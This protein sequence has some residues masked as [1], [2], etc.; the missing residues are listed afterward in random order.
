MK[1]IISPSKTMKPTISSYLTDQPPIYPKEHNEILIIL[2]KL[3]KEKLKKIMKIDKTLL[4]NT[5]SNIQNYDNLPSFHAF[6]GFNGL[7]YKG[8]K[9]E[10][11][12]K[13]EYE[14][15]THHLI[16]LDA[17]HGILKPGSLIKPYRLDMKMNIGLNLYS[18]WNISNY[19]DNELIINLASHEFS[20]MIT[21]QNI[22]NIGFLQYKN[23]KYINQAT[24]SKQARG[25]FLN[26]L[27]LN[28]ITDP[29]KMR[30]Y[31]ENRYSYNHELS[32]DLNMF[33][34]RTV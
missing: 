31:K 12:H 2:R 21:N 20:K 30:D 7:V 24:Y 17:F 28:Q 25:Q 5:F 18:F 27:I 29:S 34:T 22:L 6:E 16:I 11:Y 26:F 10:Q 19:F 15:I 13:S 32:N 1:I 14:Y 8:L 4:E 9:K 23:K 33:F 3:S